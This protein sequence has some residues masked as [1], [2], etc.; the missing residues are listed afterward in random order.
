MLMTK[1]KAFSMIE[2]IFVITIVGIL[3]AVA[4]PKLV[5]N[6]DNAAAKVCEL[7]AA[8]LITEMSSYY[9]KNSGWDSLE[10]ITNLRM[11]IIVNPGNGQNGL[12]DSRITIPAKDQPLSYICNG[13]V[14]MRITPKSRL[15][16]DHRNVEHNQYELVV[17]KPIA[18]QTQQAMIAANDLAVRNIYKSNPGYRIGGY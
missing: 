5:E 12:L 6:R 10:E 16:I 1:R 15:F 8:S 17:E 13:E 18:I 3:S 7:E 11:S 2:L 14:I 4:I 9:T